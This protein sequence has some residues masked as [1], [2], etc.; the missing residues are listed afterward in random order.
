M[1]LT[2]PNDDAD[3]TPETPTAS[4]KANN[5]TSIAANPLPRL[6]LYAQTHFH[7]NQYISLLPLIANRVPITHLIVGALHLNDGP[8]TTPATTTTT[9]P[10]PNAE[11][12]PYITLNNDPAT[13]PLLAPLH[14]DLS[15]LR[16]AGVEIHGMLGGA[17]PG[18]FTRLD[19][20]PGDAATERIRFM[21]YYTP[22]AETIRLFHFEG[23]DLD[24]EEDMSLWGIVRL[25][26]QLKSDFGSEFTITLAP[27][28]PALERRKP[29]PLWLPEGLRWRR[30]NI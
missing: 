9:D 30:F 15:I 24:V 29:E 28:A 17:A 13:S 19:E 6:I 12:A 1:P 5:D 23:L 10:T 7:K 8:T 27:V 20:Q 21:S 25:I 22:L 11:T 18:T 3:Y 26:L 4:S 14:K 16:S 2:I